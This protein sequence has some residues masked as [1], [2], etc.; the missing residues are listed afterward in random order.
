MT[1][2]VIIRTCGNLSA[3]R[4]GS[5]RTRNPV[6]LPAERQRLGAMSVFKHAGRRFVRRDL[7]ADA[8]ARVQGFGGRQ[9]TTGHRSPISF[10]GSARVQAGKQTSRRSAQT[11][12]FLTSIGRSFHKTKDRREDRSCRTPFGANPPHLRTSA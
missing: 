7:G 9:A 3:R 11:F 4:P 2:A 5:E 8:F 12:H 1:E 6:R 10:L